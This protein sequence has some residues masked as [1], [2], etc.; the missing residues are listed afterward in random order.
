MLA[1]AVTYTQV[2]NCQ[3]VRVSGGLETEEYNM[4]GESD[5]GRGQNNCRLNKCFEI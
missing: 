5:K 4:Q 3:G 2:P 1:Y